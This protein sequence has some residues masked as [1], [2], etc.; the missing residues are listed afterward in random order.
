MRKL[1]CGI[2][3]F[4]CVFYIFQKKVNICPKILLS[5]HTFCL[6]AG[7][8]RGTRHISCT[9]LKFNVNVQKRFNVQLTFQCQDQATNIIG[10]MRY[11]FTVCVQK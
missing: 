11:T 5:L 3:K 8:Q 9:C 10:D 4:F 6:Y 1:N 7:P 2:R